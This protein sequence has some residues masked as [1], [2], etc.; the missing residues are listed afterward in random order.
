MGTKAQTLKK[1]KAVIERRRKA[2]SRKVRQ[3]NPAVFTRHVEQV[4][5][6]RGFAPIRIRQFSVQT[7]FTS[8]I[9]KAIR[10]GKRNKAV[11]TDI[12]HTEVLQAEPTAC[13]RIIPQWWETIGRVAIFST[14]WSR[15]VMCPLYKEGNQDDLSNYRQACFISHDRKIIDLALLSVVCN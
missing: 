1:D 15:G 7:D 8:R 9:E 10:K 14:Q 5:R 6:Q 12:I 2:A 13:A 3:M 11:G 4:R